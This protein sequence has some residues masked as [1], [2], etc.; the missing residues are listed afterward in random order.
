MALSNV[1]MPFDDATVKLTID[2]LANAL[3]TAVLASTRLQATLTSAN[4]DVTA[5]YDALHRA[6]A[7][8]RRLQPR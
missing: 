1:G 5:L 2:E 4:D 6:A 8:L 7:T 3:Q